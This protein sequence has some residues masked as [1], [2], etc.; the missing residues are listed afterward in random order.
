MP[1]RRPMKQLVR[2]RWFCRSRPVLWWVAC[3]AAVV[4]AGWVW[5]Q[6]VTALA[7]QRAQLVRLEAVTV[8]VHPLVP[9]SVISLGDVRVE[10]RPAAFVPPGALSEPNAALGQVVREPIMANEALLPS[11]LAGPGATGVEAL[12]RP[13]ERAVSVPADDRTPPVQEGTQVDLIGT[14][15]TNG[16]AGTTTMLVEGARVIGVQ[17]RAVVVAVPSAVLAAVAEAVAHRTVV[18]AVSAGNPLPK[19]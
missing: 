12:L 15:A 8:A 16:D 18:V 3:A 10:Q 13:G 9:G 11:R 4:G 14:D 1:T 2:L 5:H 19:Q 6:Q 17:D 7:D